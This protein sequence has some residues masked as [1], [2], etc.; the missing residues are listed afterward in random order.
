VNLQLDVLDGLPPDPPP[1]EAEEGPGS[2]PDDGTLQAHLDGALSGGE[3]VEVDAHLAA[4][5]RCRSEV[6]SLAAL[7]ERVR[8]ALEGVGDSL[9]PRSRS[10]LDRARWE[11]RRQANAGRQAPR[12]RNAATATGLILVVAAIAAV[13]PGSPLRALFT[14]G[15]GAPSP[16]NEVVIPPGPETGTTVPGMTGVAVGFRDARVEVILE[17]APPGTEVELVVGT[18]ER[19]EVLAAEGTRFR[20]TTGS[21]AVELAGRQGDVLIRIPPGPGDVLLRSGLRHLARW[22]GGAF[23]FGEG[24]VADP[25]SDGVRLLVPASPE[26]GGG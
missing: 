17:D 8:D 7:G 3:A 9:L 22:S 6:E 12:R 1:R 11:A 15:G 23:Q 18:G 2:H 14:G 4:C 19:V 20:A 21:V 24:I 26:D 16:G 5:P 25:R 13:I 10:D